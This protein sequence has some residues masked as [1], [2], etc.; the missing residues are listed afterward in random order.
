MPSAKRWAFCL[1]LRALISKLIGT[2]NY[3]L[4]ANNIIPLRDRDYIDHLV[5]FHNMMVPNENQTSY[6]QNH[7][8]AKMMCTFRDGN[9]YP[10]SSDSFH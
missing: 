8:R 7:N 10:S 5:S 1:C 4:L 3:Q 2:E 9:W 6:G